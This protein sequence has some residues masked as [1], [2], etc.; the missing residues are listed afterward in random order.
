[1]PHASIARY[2]LA[3]PILAFTSGWVGSAARAPRQATPADL[4]ALEF[5]NIG[6]ANMS[7]RFVD[8]EV[9][10]GVVDVAM[11]P[12]DPS[13]LYTAAY[14]R[15]RTAYGFHGGGLHSG[16]YKSTDGG[17]TWQR[18]SGNGLPTGEYGRIGISVL[19]SGPSAGVNT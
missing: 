18:L 17:T 3:G 11:D 8:L 7:G 2:A 14:Q 19:G 5:P 9:V 1:M 16:L 4:S 15:R 13:I 10:T 12:S 6:P